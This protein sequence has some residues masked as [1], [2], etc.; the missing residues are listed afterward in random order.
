MEPTAEDVSDGQTIVKLLNPY[1]KAVTQFVANKTDSVSLDSNDNLV[2]GE[3]TYELTSE[4]NITGYTI[5]GF[6]LKDGAA[7]VEDYL[8]SDKT[9]ASIGVD[10]TKDSKTYNYKLNGETL[11]SN[12]AFDELVTVESKVT[13][14]AEGAFDPFV[15]IAIDQGA[16]Y[17]EKG[18]KFRYLPIS[19]TRQFQFYAVCD[20]DFV[21]ITCNEA[22]NEFYAN[23]VKMNLGTSGDD[24]YYRFAIERRTTK[25]PF[26]WAKMEK[27]ATNTYMVYNY[28]TNIEDLEAGNAQAAKFVEA[29]TCFAKQNLTLDLF[30]ED[31]SGVKT[32]KASKRLFDSYFSVKI[33]STDK[34][35]ARS[36]VKYRY[37]FVPAREEGSEEV[38][39]TTIEAIIYG[40]VVTVNE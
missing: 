24:S 4:Y 7:T 39:P 34:L 31:N 36:Y 14:P 9:F 2:V 28:Y 13:K 21:D 33:T 26:I 40:D 6:K 20:L 8:N 27:P 38:E 29:G 15:A 19:Y 32:V 3:N 10:F 1:D 11:K 18:C 16:D 35:W 12:V 22:M 25:M 23:G 5:N 17:A 37:S 30:K